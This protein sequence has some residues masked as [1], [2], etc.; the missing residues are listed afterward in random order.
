[1]NVVNLDPGP[2]S[3]RHIGVEEDAVVMEECSPV[4][5]EGN[6]E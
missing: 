4:T 5:S 2:G 3:E 6:A 1:M